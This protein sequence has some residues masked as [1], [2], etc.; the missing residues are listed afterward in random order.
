MMW[1]FMN[2]IAPGLD[3]LLYVFFSARCNRFK[4]EQS[5]GKFARVGVCFF[6]LKIFF[7]AF[8]VGYSEYLSI[9]LLLCFCCLVYCGSLQV[10]AIWALIAVV[11]NG[12]IN[13][14]V[15]SCAVAIPGIPYEAFDMPGIVRTACILIS[16][17]LLFGC[18]YVMTINNQRAAKVKWS[19]AILLMFLSVGCWALLEIFFLY[20]DAVQ[21]PLAH[22]G[23]QIIASAGMLIV[24][25]ASTIL[26]NQMGMQEKEYAGLQIRLKATQMT[27]D[28]IKQQN[29]VYE[30]I[31]HHVE[32]HFT[33]I[34]SLLADNQIDA[35]KAYII[36]LNPS[37]QY[38]TEYVGN[39]V[40][41]ALIRARVSIA[42]SKGIDFTVQIVL[43]DKM[44]ISDVSLNI[45]FGSLLDNAFEAVAKMPKT[46]GCFIEIITKVNESH[47]M[48]ACR[49]TADRKAFRTVDHIPSTKIDTELH[50]V[51]T[52][53]IVDIAR[54]TGGYAVFEQ[55]D[56]VFTASALLK[57][58][59]EET[60][61]E[62]I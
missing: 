51:G 54:N 8:S 34:S 58:D 15:L 41:D 16:K 53:H 20:S 55:K 44:P 4:I 31:H 56:A 46:E 37:E 6:L 52:R 9:L 32:N 1:S 30:R 7:S 3:T 25:M 23:L 43:P 61:T 50:G 11:T 14:F 21:E 48:I 12:I 40:L 57:L 28:H 33:A 13:F 39:I 49:N 10:Y 29:V 2:I 42:K 24:M 47:W 38:E 27:S 18:Y 26:Y 35:A 17:C 5:K 19:N 36:E 62:E 45:L 60:H 59:Q 22:Y